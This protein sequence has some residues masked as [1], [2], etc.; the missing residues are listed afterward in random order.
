MGAHV[1]FLVF[2]DGTG[3]LTIEGLAKIQLRE[4]LL[5]LGA[6]DVGEV[7]GSGLGESELVHRE[8]MGTQRE[9]ELFNV[10]D[11]GRKRGY[12][13]PEA[14]Q[15]GQVSVPFHGRSG[16]GKIRCLESCSVAPR[17]VE[18]SLVDSA[19]VGARNEG[20]KDSY[21]AGKECAGKRAVWSEFHV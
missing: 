12:L 16:A 18:L 11:E 17:S 21:D 8:N 4:T 13:T 7:L 10:I 9:I 2:G 3:H 6:C 1:D 15:L 5:I 14:K 20:G 19:G